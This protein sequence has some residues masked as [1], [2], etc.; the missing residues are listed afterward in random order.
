MLLENPLLPM[1]VIALL[2]GFAAWR[3]RL[4]AWW[5]L[6]PG[7]VAVGIAVLLYSPVASCNASQS[8]ETAFAAAI[9][10]GV[11]FYLG[12][13]VAAVMEGIALAREHDYSRAAWRLLPFL[14][15]AALAIVTAVLA[16]FSL[17]GCL[18]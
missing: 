6:I 16:L 4:S 15:G 3:L 7:T 11:G 2:A 13:S 12:T 17:L 1:A 18:S 9:V 8:A 5:I 14:A 10:I